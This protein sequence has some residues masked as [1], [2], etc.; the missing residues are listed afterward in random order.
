MDDIKKGDVPGGGVMDRI[1]RSHHTLEVRQGVEKFDDPN[2]SAR[3]IK[4][5]GLCAWRGWAFGKKED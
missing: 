5:E 3:K 1:R 4:G 2:Q